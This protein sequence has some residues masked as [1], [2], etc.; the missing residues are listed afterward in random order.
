MVQFAFLCDGTN[1][2][3]VT[4]NWADQ[5]DIQT[6]YIYVSYTYDA[7]RHQFT[8]ATIQR[9]THRNDAWAPE[10]IEWRHLTPS[11]KEKLRQRLGEIDELGANNHPLFRTP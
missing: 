5:A 9:Y 4:P 2:L 6:V 10:F 11:T 8:L 1:I 7:Q 3:Q